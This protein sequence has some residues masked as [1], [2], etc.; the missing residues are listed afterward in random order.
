MDKP[1]RSVARLGAQAAEALAYA[2]S[3]GVTHR[4]IKPGNLLLDENGNS[5]VTADE[6]AED[7]QRFLNNEPIHARRPAFWERGIKW[8][9]RH[10]QAAISAAAFLLP[11]VWGPAFGAFGVRACSQSQTQQRLSLAA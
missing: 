1:V 9:K 5:W 6:L 10:Q 3:L 8:C 11:S 2:H 7:L 4:D